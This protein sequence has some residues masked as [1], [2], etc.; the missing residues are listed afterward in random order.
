VSRCCLLAFGSA[1]LLACG[2][3]P[4]GTGGGGGA[5]GAGGGAGGGADGGATEAGGGTG[6]GGGAAR[7]AIDVLSGTGMGLQRDARGVVHVLSQYQGPFGTTAAVSYGRCASRCQLPESWT[8]LELDVAGAQQTTLAVSAAGKVVVMWDVS[9]ADVIGYT[10]CDAAD[11]SVRSAWTAPAT[12]LGAP[13][14]PDSRQI[15]GHRALA[16]DAAGA[17]HL[18]LSWSLLDTAN[19]NRRAVQHA[20]CSS[21][22]AAA[23]GW[24]V[25]SLPDS[26]SC[27]HASTAAS[28]GTVGI[29][30]VSEG[31]PATPAITLSYFGCSGGCAASS[32]W[33]SAAGF[34]GVAAQNEV[35]L[36]F[37]GQAPRMLFADASNHPTLL[38]CS[39][40]CAQAA[41][42]AGV[43]FAQTQLA[44]GTGRSSGDSTARLAFA[45]EPSGRT[46]IAWTEDA[47]VVVRTCQGACLTSGS[48]WAS[49]V[50]DSDAQA[51]L[52]SVP[53]SCTDG[54]S[55]PFAYASIDSSIDLAVVGQQVLVSD[56]SFDLAGCHSDASGVDVNPRL[57]VAVAPL[58]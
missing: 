18:A 52:T 5:P 28:A 3:S 57:R 54:H 26:V 23:T 14:G 7:G 8:K 2:A 11:C 19:G 56:S 27:S 55:G 6:S 17:L 49:S 22:C 21:G 29:A 30:C 34:Y 37:E 58:P 53:P 50:V 43:Y 46:T 13:G 38:G 20:A 25:T 40:S 51:T 48:S 39:T 32:S 41:Q 31:T 12:V 47:S 36:A 42:W 15:P 1:A 33:T 35:Q 9:R 4:T 16:F 10:E 24:Q 44:A 45:L